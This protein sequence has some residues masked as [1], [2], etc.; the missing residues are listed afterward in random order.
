MEEPSDNQKTEEKIVFKKPV[1][2]GRIGKLP[3]KVKNDS[4]ET[5][6]AENQQ[7]EK[8]GSNTARSNERG[9]ESPVIIAND[10]LSMPIPYKEPKWSGICPD[11][12]DY[13]LEVLKSGMIVDKMDLTK[14][15]FYVFGRLNNCDVMMAH[16]TISR[17]HCVLQYKAFAEEGE[18]PCGWYLYDLGS[19]HGTFL[20][21]D[22]LKVSHYT[23][24]RVGHQIKFGNSTRTYILLGP[25]FDAEGES[26]LSVTEI[27]QRANTMKVER[28]R[29][30]QDAIE[31]R[32]RERKE[33]ER[34]RDEMGI[35]WGM[36]EDAEEEPD[37]AD[38]PYAVTANEEL[39]LEDPKKTLRGYFEREGHELNYNCDEKGVGQFV[40]RVELPIDD[41]RGNP[42]VAE[43][44][45]KGKKKE[46]VIACALEACRILDRA[47]LLRQSKHESRKRKERDWSADDFYDSDDDTF[48][49]RTGSVERK[50]KLRMQKHGAAPVEDEKPR[51]YDDLLKEIT[52]IEKKIATEEKNLSALRSSSTAG[53]QSSEEVDEL[54]HFMNNLSKQGQSMATKA[55]ISRTKMTIQ[56][57]KADLSKTQR[58]AE[59]AR[60]AHLPPLVKKDTKIHIKQASNS[61]VY[62]KRLILKDDT[63]K[64]VKVRKDVKQEESEFVEEMDDDDDDDDHSSNNHQKE[65]KKLNTEV[66]AREVKRNEVE[67]E[68]DSK[69]EEGDR[70]ESTK[71]KMYGPMRPP[72]NYVIPEDYYDQTSDRD[73]PEIMEK[74][75]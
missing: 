9:K 4:E 49:D 41:A 25:D 6:D 8:S 20:N 12:T 56:K 19:T 10:V 37:L 57:L 23:R 35:D 33:E 69:V 5:T 59:L 13:S 46:A 53:Q 50:R 38:N 36:G 52:E 62:G 73:L 28:D 24:V 22:R 15:A 2:F 47:G 40:C 3:K 75:T 61:A 66:D 30:I 16:P 74:E 34:R 65:E 71:T 1:L 18:P 70:Q 72:E 27:K 44:I 21:K 60:P 48:L 67:K 32:E 11:G 55:E 31:Q 14:R 58:L 68:G 7:Q 43:V 17:Y 42:V 29:M 51:T 63:E 45:H 26:E 64:K 54:D 39:Y